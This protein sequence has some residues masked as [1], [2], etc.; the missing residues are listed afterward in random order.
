MD[1]G[2]IIAL[3]P[4]SD[5]YFSAI[6]DRAASG[7]RY[8]LRLDGQPE[9]YPDP[10]SRFQPDGPHGASQIADAGTFRWSDAQW[11]GARIEGQI[12]YEMH[13]GTFTAEGTWEAAVKELPQLADLGVTILEIMPVAAFPGRFG[14]GYDGVCLFAPT[15]LYGGPDDFRRF[16]DRAHALGL[17]VILDVVY[18][19][20]GPDGNYLKQF[21]ADYFTDKYAN[22]W[23]EPI[24]FDGTNCGPVREFFVANARYWIEEFHLDG[25]RLDATQQIFDDSSEHILAAIAR[26]ARKTALPR[27]IILV[28]ENEQQIANLA[29]GEPDGG[30]GLDALWNDDFHHTARVALTKRCEAYYSDYRGTPQEFISALKWGFL[31]QGQRYSWQK[32]LRGKPALDLKPASFVIYIQNHD[33]IANWACSDRLSK[34]SSPAMLRAVTALLLLAPGTP[35]LFQG[36]EFGATSP[37]YYFADH[38]PELAPLV[39]KGRRKFLEQFKSIVDSAAELPSPHNDATFHASKLKLDERDRHPQTVALHRD[40]IRLRRDDPVFKAQRTDWLQ[41]AVLGTHA[42]AIRL[43]A[44]EVGDRL[45]LVNLGTDLELTPAPE[46]LLAPPTQRP[47]RI[48]WSSE[49]TKY[50]GCGRIPVDAEGKWFLTGQ[51]TIILSS[52]G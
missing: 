33:Q 14:W 24:N 51:S 32:G 15:E 52:E 36:Q 5:G 12:I 31:Y 13:I 10:A 29:R 42:F 25:L 43:L 40:L 48:L 11:R 41:G 49:F 17:G 23:G 35:M 1:D 7:M 9:L 30:V 19:H 50:G 8:R 38:N 16:V 28:A 4:E 22:E 37:F 27:D 6:D 46:P 3:Q 39:E 26:A 47:W 20:L 21:S 45:M 18:N 34:H 2:R 44:G